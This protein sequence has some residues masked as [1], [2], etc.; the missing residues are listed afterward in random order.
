MTDPLD[1]F[2]DT[3][4]P[5]TEEDPETAL[6]RRVGP[7]NEVL[8]DALIL[9]EQMETWINEDPIGKYLYAQ[10]NERITQCTETLF[11]L[12]SLDN[13]KAVDAHF[14][15]R[16]AISML[17]LIDDAIKAGRESAQLISSQDGSDITGDEA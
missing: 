7:E 15:G 9:S 2:R 14:N 11:S 17:K 3:R 12:P 10:A 13:P 6:R 16:V 4:P 8:V 1:G 5:A